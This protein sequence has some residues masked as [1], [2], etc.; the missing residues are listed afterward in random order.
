MNYVAVTFDT[1]I[2]ETL[3]RAIIVL[4]TLLKSAKE[5]DRSFGWC[6]DG[7]T[8]DQNHI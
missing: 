5:E 2:M 1:G 4:I 6:G 3:M 7:E 8:E